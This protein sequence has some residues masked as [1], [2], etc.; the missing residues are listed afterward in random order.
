MIE[1]IQKLIYNLKYRDALKLLKIFF[2][3][4]GVELSLEILAYSCVCHYIEESTCID[5]LDT[6]STFVASDGFDDS[7][8]KKN[9]KTLAWVFEAISDYISDNTLVLN[10]PIDD[11]L[12]HL[13]IFE[14]SIAQC[15]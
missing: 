6:L 11:V 1:K 2:E 5:Q 10:E 8:V 9:T 12:S 3:Q 14:K 7:K 13:L 4:E 15:N